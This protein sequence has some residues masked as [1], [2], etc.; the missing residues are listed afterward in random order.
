MPRYGRAPRW[1]GIGVPSVVAG[2]AARYVAGMTTERVPDV[3]GALVALMRG[4][5]DYAGLFPPGGLAMD[6]AVRRYA[7]YRKGGHR[8]M[9]GRFVVHATRLDELM[10][11]ASRYLRSGHVTDPWRLSV[12]VGPDTERDLARVV[13]LGGEGGGIMADS[14]EAKAVSADGVAGLAAALP[15]G[16]TAYV[17]LPVAADPEPLVRA[18]AA[19][20]LRA[21]ARTGGVTRDLV[22]SS[23]AVAGFVAA[24]ARHDVPF[25]LTA[26]LHHAIRASY[27]LTYAPDSPHATM[28]GFLNAFVAAALARA[29]EPTSVVASV[30]EETEREAFSFD[31]RALH[32]RGHPVQTADIER[33]RASFA[34]AFGSCSFH[35]PVAELGLGDAAGA[36]L[37]PRG[38]APHHLA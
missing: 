5:V 1:R 9:L 7:A 17:E 15:P 37:A 30:L 25:K 6:E 34:I 20:R 36:D 21:K 26:G 14:V 18:V 31:D 27:P 33:M 13:Q 12:L 35:E 24:C 4:S 22:P 11:A 23:A 29:G 32:W 19:A 38:V 8:W 3:P 16:I 2:G 28:F 10:A